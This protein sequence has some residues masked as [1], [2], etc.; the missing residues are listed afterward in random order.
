MPWDNT[1]LEKAGNTADGQ[2]SFRHYIKDCSL[3]VCN[4]CIY[5]NRPVQAGGDVYLPARWPPECLQNDTEPVPLVLSD[6]DKG[7]VCL[8]S[9]IS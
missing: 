4:S 8:H 7:E 6:E 3:D 9:F 5:R 1:L 2:I